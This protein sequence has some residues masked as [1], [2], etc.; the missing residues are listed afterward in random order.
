MR[1]CDQAHNSGAR[2]NEKKS[3][4]KFGTKL[5]IALAH[6]LKARINLVLGEHYF[7]RVSINIETNKS[8]IM[9]LHRNVRLTIQNMFAKDSIYFSLALY[10]ANS[11][12]VSIYS[13]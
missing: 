4:S 12:P 2:K 8:L 7:L 13:Y 9:M 1:S 11:R 6:V 5:T 3:V 10:F